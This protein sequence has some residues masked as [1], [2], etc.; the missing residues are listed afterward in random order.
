[1]NSAG[2]IS[3]S[4][5]CGPFQPKNRK[6]LKLA[7]NTCLKLSP[8][9]DCSRAS[10]GPSRAWDVSK[11]TAMD[12]MFSGAK[13]FNQDLSNWN[14]DKV[15]DM[16]YMFSGAKSFNQD[17]SNWNVDKVTDMSKMFR[18]AI[19]FNQVLCGDEWANSKASQEDM[20]RDS[21]GSISS[22]TCFSSKSDLMDAVAS[23]LGR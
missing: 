19:S 9:G 10:Y 14:V 13:Y 7:V 11:I 6:Y 15:T 8:V 5:S 18:G 4:I 21:R 2:T 23:C 12:N 3:L 20:F 17:L 16:S 22:Q 1:M